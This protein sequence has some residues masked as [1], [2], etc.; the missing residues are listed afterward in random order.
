LS[1]PWDV[2]PLPRSGDATQDK[3]FAYV[4]FVMT[5]WESLEFELSRLHSMFLGAFDET[6]AMRA[7]GKGDTFL[8]RKT[9]LKESAEAQFRTNPNQKRE[10]EF[11]NLLTEASGYAD[12]RNE[13]AHGMV[14]RIDEITLF[15]K[16]LK[17]QLLKREHYALIAPLYASKAH[18]PLDFPRMPTRRT[19]WIGSRN[20]S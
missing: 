12:R 4:G 10:G 7:Y 18:L 2:P 11:D 3:T 20:A 13:I 9:I 1:K 14:F 16:H 15:R 5:R 8:R 17:P 19:L 6:E